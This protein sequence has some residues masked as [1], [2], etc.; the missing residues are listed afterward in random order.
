MLE[1]ISANIQV[2]KVVPKY[3]NFNIKT[4][5]IRHVHTFGKYEVFRPENTLGFQRIVFMVCVKSFNLSSPF[6][7]II[8]SLLGHGYICLK[9]R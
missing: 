5:K 3:L 1:G 4:T 7:F 2:K 6:F 8:N 9:K